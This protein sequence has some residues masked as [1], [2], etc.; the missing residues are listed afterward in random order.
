LDRFDAASKSNL[1][2]LLVICLVVGGAAVIVAASG[3]ATSQSAPEIN[4]TVSDSSNGADTEKVP[5]TV[6]PTGTHEPTGVNQQLFDTVS[7]FDGT[8]SGEFDGLSG[9][10]LSTLRSD[11]ISGNLDKE[12]FQDLENP[13]PGRDYSQLRSYLV[14]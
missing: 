7:S 9:R 11:L 13:P 1:S 14:G 8:T 6:S 10:D 3:S 12:A 2:T 4:I 5:I